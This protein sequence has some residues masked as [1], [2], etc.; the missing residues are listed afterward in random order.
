M[1]LQHL[2][3]KIEGIEF[4][5]NIDILSGFKIFLKALN[6]DNT[7]LALVEELEKHPQ[8]KQDVFQRI[9]FLLG[10]NEQAEYMHPYDAALAGYLYALS[11]VD[12]PLTHKAIEI[13]LQTPQLWWARRL[14]KHLQEQMAHEKL[15]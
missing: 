7:L 12:I 3:E 6:A 2:F 5:T 9:Q 15:T 13:I 4:A 8:Q 11:R 10:V 14:A 1:S